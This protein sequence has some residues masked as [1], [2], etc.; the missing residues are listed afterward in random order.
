MEVGTRGSYYFE[1]FES[2]LINSYFLVCVK[3][4]VSDCSQADI[5]IIIYKLWKLKFEAYSVYQ[6]CESVLS[7][8]ETHVMMSSL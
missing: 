7:L 1:D 4:G 6:R 2:I 8:C 5:T 3:V